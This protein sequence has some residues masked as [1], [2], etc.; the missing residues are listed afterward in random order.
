MPFKT[1]I[2]S[3]NFHIYFVVTCKMLSINKAYVSS[4]LVISEIYIRI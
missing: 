2:R 1:C 3:A 4:Y